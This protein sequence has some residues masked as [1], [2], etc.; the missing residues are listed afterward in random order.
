MKKWTWKD[1]KVGDRVR[2]REGAIFQIVKIWDDYFADISEVCIADDGE[3]CLDRPIR[4]Y[5]K[6]YI[7]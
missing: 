7:K 3:E 5:R 2:D 6:D 4:A 1:L